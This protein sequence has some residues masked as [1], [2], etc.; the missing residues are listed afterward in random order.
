MDYVNDDDGMWYISIEDFH[1]SFSTTAANYNVDSFHHTH[2]AAFNVNTPKVSD[3]PR[4]DANLVK[5][6]L[7]ISSEV[8]QM[9]YLS[10]YTH[11]RQHIENSGCW[12][13]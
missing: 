11:N 6:V 12:T 2:Y 3:H 1:R 7:K 5:E 8:D 13:D 4:S 9:V 10:A